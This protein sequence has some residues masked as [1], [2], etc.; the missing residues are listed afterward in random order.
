[1]SLRHPFFSFVA[2]TS[3]FS[4]AFEVSKAEGTYIYDKNNTPYLDLISGIAVA[5]IG[6]SN[7]KVIEA[8][9]NQAAKYMHTMVYGEHVQSPQVQLAET[10]VS[11]LPP[12]LNNVF[13]V[14]SGSEA[15]DGALKLARKY[16]GRT[17]IISFENAYH[18]STW[19]ALSA[20]GNHTYK[21]T[22]APL[23]PDFKTLPFNNIQRLE[24]ISQNTA[25]VIIEPIQGEAGVVV[26]QVE[27]IRRL[28]EICNK[29][30]VLIIADEIQTGMGRTGKF[31]ACSHFNLKP[32]IL[33]LAKAMGG[34]MPIGAFISNIE[35]MKTLR[36]NPILGHI[37]T[38]GGHPVSAAA[39]L[40][41]LHVLLQENI[42][43]QVQE[44]ESLFRKNLKH[45]LIKNI[46]GKGLMLALE[47][48]SFEMVQTVIKKA[49]EYQ[50]LLD[51]FLFNDTHIRLAPPLTIST[52]EIELA[53]T[54]FLDILDNLYK[55]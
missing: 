34:G 22:Y 30:N 37:S 1:M 27:F 18:G 19:G 11:V 44:K 12:Y 15:V 52:H 3:D 29:N 8:I 16:T 47:F 13:F 17:E 20:M 36:N 53:C 35:I 40:A 28:Q 54:R 31:L 24:E 51:W 43:N 14:N 39:A 55:P 10:L 46:R 5:N 7:P 33:L 6:H 23:I 45:P 50:L 25:A 48:E 26:P 42:I 4:M 2:Q 32:D 41:A 49:F 38:F 21:N 9:H